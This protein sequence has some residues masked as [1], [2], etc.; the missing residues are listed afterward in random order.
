MVVDGIEKARFAL[1]QAEAAAAL[2]D[3]LADP[4]AQRLVARGVFVAL[5][6]FIDIARQ[7]RN[8]VPKTKANETNLADVK[9][10]L[11]ALAERDWGPYRPLR[12][13]IGAHRQPIEVRTARCRGTPPTNFSPRSTGL[14]SKC[15][16]TTCSRS[17]TISPHSSVPTHSSRPSS[18]PIDSL[19]SSRLGRSPGRVT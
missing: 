16:S 12:D 3:A 5:V 10:A 7:T 9:A 11:N 19:A 13:R 4:F 1:T 17:S 14:W 18:Q 6:S 2:A 8:Q 15:F